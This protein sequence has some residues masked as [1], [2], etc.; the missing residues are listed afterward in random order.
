M[1]AT[2][3][4]S[5]VGVFPRTIM[6]DQ[7]FVLPLHFILLLDAQLMSTI[8]KGKQS[9]ET[10]GVNMRKLYVDKLKFLHPT[11]D[12]LHHKDI[13]LRSTDYART[14]E[15][16]QYLVNGL[17]PIGARDSMDPTDLDLKVHMRSD[18]NSESATHFQLLMG[19]VAS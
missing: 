16:L 15:S 9:L 19:W 14:L 17:Y 3:D 7:Y 4:S 6:Q 11:I 2:L 10:M 1:N 18:E 13:Y 8:D 12:S 5:L